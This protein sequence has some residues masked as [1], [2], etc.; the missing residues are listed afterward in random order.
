MQ[1]RLGMLQGQVETKG[2]CLGDPF[3]R[4]AFYL[5]LPEHPVLDQRAACSQTTFQSA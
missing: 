2:K 1:R 3:P 4:T 5:A